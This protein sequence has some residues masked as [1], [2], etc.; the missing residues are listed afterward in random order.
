[1]DYYMNA[2]GLSSACIREFETES[3]TDIAKGTALSVSDGKVKVAADGE[4]ILGI[5]ASDYHAEKDELIPES[6]NGRIRV[7]I[8][9]DAIYKIPLF[10]TTLAGAGTKTSLTVS[11]LSLPTAAGALKGGYVKLVS[12]TE[13]STNTDHVGVARKITASSGASLT[14]SEGGA[15]C[16]GDVYAI[17]P[18]VGF[19]YLA[20]SEDARSFVTASS[21]KNVAKVVSALAEA[22]FSEVVLTNTFIG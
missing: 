15:P 16:A 12:K 20:L 5:C 22:D 9:G 17:I 14:L 18:P 3:N 19:E 8:S 7:I 4:V 11:G 6:G 1:M 10:R 13:T 21:K 2:A